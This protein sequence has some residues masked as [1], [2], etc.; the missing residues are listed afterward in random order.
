MTSARS[1]RRD[2]ATV[3][4]LLFGMAAFTCLAVCAVG[5][6]RDVRHALALNV[7]GHRR[8][9]ADAIP[10]AVN[11]VRVTVTALGGSV[12]V[13]RFPRARPVLDVAL[14][15]VLA[16]NAALLGAAIGAYGGPLLEDL[17]W[18]G[19][20]EVSGFAIAGAAYLDARRRASIRWQRLGSCIAL[21]WTFLLAA[22]VLE[23]V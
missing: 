13:A 21:S 11:N 6:S 19:P 23:L 20:L 4:G 9:I 12:I 2:V 1:L 14:V 18:H 8:P 16:I 10:I 17:A 5:L 3:A 7:G 22:A 15:A